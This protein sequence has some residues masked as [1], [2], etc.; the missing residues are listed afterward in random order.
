M[1]LAAAPN[2]SSGCCCCPET[3]RTDVAITGDLAPKMETLTRDSHQA[4]PSVLAFAPAPASAAGSVARPSP[5]PIRGTHSGHCHIRNRR[6]PTS[7]CLSSAAKSTRL[8]SRSTC[9]TRSDH[10]WWQ[11]VAIGG[12][13]WQSA[14]PNRCEPFTSEPVAIIG[15]Q[16]HLVAISCEPFTSEF[17]RLASRST[18]SVRSV[19]LAMKA[20]TSR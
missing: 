15:N 17:V 18:R 20:S 8:A 1:P 19:K 3:L 6:R 11:L 9:H 16:R 5:L 4:P 12:N 13:W 7:I 2:C 10:I 14:N